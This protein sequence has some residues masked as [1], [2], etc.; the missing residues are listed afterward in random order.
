MLSIK[1][2]LGLLIF[3]LLLILLYFTGSKS[4]NSEILID[5]KSDKV[6]SVIINTD[7]YKKWNPVMQLVGGELKEG[8]KLTYQ[9]TQDEEHVSQIPVTVVKMISNRLLNQKGG[10]PFILTFNHVYELTT[11][12]KGTKLIIHENYR[13]I[14]VNFWNP[15]PVEEAYN[16]LSL[17][18][19]K[20]AESKK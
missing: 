12:S 19:K 6:W 7:T 9:F 10:L 11:V 18:I 5:A 13:G 8:A 3:V 1:V 20:E 15:K 2:L 16:R 14:W 17:A 4:V